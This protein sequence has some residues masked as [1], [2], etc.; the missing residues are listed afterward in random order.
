MRV[1]TYKK[2]DVLGAFKKM[3]ADGSAENKTGFIIEGTK[4]INARFYHDG[5]LILRTAVPKGRGDIS[6]GVQRAI[7]NQLK[8]NREEFISFAGC[9]MKIEDF[10]DILK[11]INLINNGLP[12]N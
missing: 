3:K 7:M 9:P 5:N 12:Q 2:N 6:P 1:P 11:T 4:E 10:L 8:M